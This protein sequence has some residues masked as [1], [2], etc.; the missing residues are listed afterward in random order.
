MNLYHYYEKATGPFI[1]LSDLSTLKAQD[2]LHEI[3]QS[4]VTMAARRNDGYL[5]RRREL[6]QIAR[7]LFQ[8]KG[9]KP[10]RTVP[11]YMVVE[12]CAWL[13]S[14]YVQGEYIKI[15]IT[16]FDLN[17]ISFSYGDMFPTFSSIV[18]DGREYRKQIYTYEEIVEIIQRYGL[19]QIWNKDG[20]FGPERYIEVQVWSDEPLEK[21][22]KL[23]HPRQASTL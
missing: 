16:E 11:H 6:E 19:P 23:E 15:P 20:Q 3:K 22:Y 13:K 17:T 12:E 10:I 18:T 5:D 21:Y 2:V 7:D 1:N 8:S 14:W 9:G 4:N